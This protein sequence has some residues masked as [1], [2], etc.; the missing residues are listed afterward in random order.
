[1]GRCGPY[2]EEMK[3]SGN[4]RGVARVGRTHQLRIICD[5][6]ATGNANGATARLLLKR[7]DNW[8][9]AR[10]PNSSQQ[11]KT[12]TRDTKVGSLASR[13]CSHPC[14]GLTGGPSS[15]EEALMHVDVMSRMPPVPPN[16]LSVSQAQDRRAVIAGMHSRARAAQLKRN[17]NSRAQAPTHAE[18]LEQPRRGLQRNDQPA[19]CQGTAQTRDGAWTRISRELARGRASI[20]ERWGGSQRA[21]STHEMGSRQRN[22]LASLG[23]WLSGVTATVCAFKVG[24]LARGPP[25]RVVLSTHVWIRNLQPSGRVQDVLYVSHNS[26][27]MEDVRI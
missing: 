7:M 1:M 20:W 16:R 2:T 4:P 3:S 6:K 12:P 26:S 5:A 21:H 18:S 22:K 25:Q 11:S 10:C 15:S 8:H 19:S 9:I 24:Q 14:P 23:L 13:R 27:V 17:T